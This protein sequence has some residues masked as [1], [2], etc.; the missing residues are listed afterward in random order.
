MEQEKKNEQEKINDF[1]QKMKATFDSFIIDDA[2][3]EAREKELEEHHRQEKERIKYENYTKCG[4]GAKYFDKSIQT[5]IPGNENEKRILKAV[6]EF[7]EN[8]KNK[9]LLLYGNYGTGKTHLACGILRE[10]EGLYITS[11][12][13]CIEYETGADFNAKKNRLEVINTYSRSR[14][15]VIDEVGR[16]FNK[17]LEQNLLNYIISERYANNLPIVL[18]TNLSKKDFVEFLGLAVF[19]RLTETCISLEFSGES[20]RKKR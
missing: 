14:M 18:I 5:F 11:Q 16:S 4:V 2:E 15:L 20:Y 3:V 8:P 1:T 9:T 19:D 6:N 12:K 7:V 10:L 13:L 17:S